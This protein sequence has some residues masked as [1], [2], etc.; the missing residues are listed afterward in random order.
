MT[1]QIEG[2]TFFSTDVSEI[3]LPERFTYPFVYQTHP[4]CE[5]AAQEVQGRLLSEAIPHN[6][7]INNFK[8]GKSLGKMFGVLVVKTARG[9]LGYLAAFSGRL[10]KQNHYPGFVPPV[11]DTLHPG[12][13][14]LEAE[15]QLDAINLAVSKIESSEEYQALQA[16]L[17]H[18][19]EQAAAAIAKSKAQVK[20]Q[21]QQRK[22]QRIDAK[23]TLAPE[24][25]QEL[26]ANLNQESAQQ[27]FEHKD[28]VKEWK[29]AIQTAENELQA[30]KEKL[31]ALKQQRKALSNA[32][33]DRI[34]EAYQFLNAKGEVRSLKSIFGQFPPPSGAGE[35]AAPRLLQYAYQNQLKPIAMA[36]FWW[37]EPPL[38][39]VRQHQHY[40]PACR[41]KCEPILS[42]MLQGLEVDP[43]PLLT[44]PGLDKKIEFLYEDEAILLV[45]KPPELLSVPGKNIRDSVLWRVQQKYPEL[46]GPIIVH[47]LDMS[48]SGLMVLAKNKAAYLHLQT[49]FIK[50]RVKKRYTARLTG[51]PKM[52]GGKIELPLRVDLDNRP[53]QLVCYAHGKQALTEWQ[54]VEVQNQQALVHFFPVTGR[55]HQL[56]VHAAHHLGLGTPILGDDLYGKVADRLYLHAAELSFVHPRTEQPMNFTWEA[57]F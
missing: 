50:R 52:K 32:T 54:L 48:T 57:A 9:Q 42:H 5:M 10:G 6:F 23:T 12:S 35:C 44:N 14:F 16:T 36:E 46:E 21:K 4:L 28:L 56:R 19:K 7:G 25:Y 41:G 31:Q 18:Q 27:H 55:T 43:N 34:F 51:I 39:E 47:R 53:R 45:K 38:S 37:G 3:P 40:Y 17:S 24:A 29:R 22:Q 33:Q 8:A 2:L 20:S 1:T 49:Q 30:S 13:F 15:A 11:F 26:E